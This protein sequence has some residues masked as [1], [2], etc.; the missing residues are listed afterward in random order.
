MLIASLFSALNAAAIAKS[1]PNIA[2][3][4]RQLDVCT[5]RLHGMKKRM[6]GGN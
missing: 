2:L 6:V 5:A 3:M 1:T 4:T